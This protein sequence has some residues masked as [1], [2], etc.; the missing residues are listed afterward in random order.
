MAVHDGATQ[1][2]AIGPMREEIEAWAVEARWAELMNPGQ[3][4]WT[5]IEDEGDE[6]RNL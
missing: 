4:Y 5:E 6:G 3:A 1:T 2:V